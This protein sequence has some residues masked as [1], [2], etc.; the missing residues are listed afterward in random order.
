MYASQHARQQPAIG[1]PVVTAM[2]VTNPRADSGELSEFPQSKKK[3]PYGWLTDRPR[4]RVNRHSPLTGC[5]VNPSDHVRANLHNGLAK[6]T[7]GHEAAFRLCDLDARP[8]L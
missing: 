8:P 2:L 4:K 5:E 6:F 1:D 3:P 7:L